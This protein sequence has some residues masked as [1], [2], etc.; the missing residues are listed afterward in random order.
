MTHKK[1]WFSIEIVDLSIE[2]GGF[3]IKNGG[4]SNWKWWFSIKNGGFT[5]EKIVDFPVRSD[6][7]A[8]EL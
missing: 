7:R 8:P 2:N 5:N 3:S 6:A 4:F 1:W